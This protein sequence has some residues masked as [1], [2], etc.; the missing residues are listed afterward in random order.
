[1]KNLN[2]LGTIRLAA[3]LLAISLLSFTAEKY[4][5]FKFTDAQLT[6]HW[7]KLNAIKQLV[8]GSDMPHQQAKFITQS[9][10]SLQSDIATQVIPQQA[11]DTTHH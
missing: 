8:D 7:T 5:T 10:D 11:A 9:L 1:M 6:K 4:Y 2:C 3:L